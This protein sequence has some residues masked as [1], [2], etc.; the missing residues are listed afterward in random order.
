MAETH[1]NSEKI[2]DYSDS[3]GFWKSLVLW[4]EPRRGS[5]CICYI[6]EAFPKSYCKA[7]K[8]AVCFTTVWF[9]KYLEACSKLEGGDLR[10]LPECSFLWQA[11]F[12]EIQVRKVGLFF[13]L[14]FCRIGSFS[15]WTW[16]CSF[17]W[18]HWGRVRGACTMR[19][20]V[21]S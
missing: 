3:P 15:R 5:V 8:R 14:F 7:A 11:I 20:R 18:S 17:R 13:I 16:T 10:V 1:L 19:N 2:L 9:W 4:Q 6:L 21:T 12:T